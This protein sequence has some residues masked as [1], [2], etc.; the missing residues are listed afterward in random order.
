MIIVENLVN[1]EKLKW[2]YKH[3]LY[4][5]YPEITSINILLYVFLGFLQ[6]F[7]FKIKIVI[8]MQ[9]KYLT[10]LFSL[11]DCI[12]QNISHFQKFYGLPWW[13]KGYNCELPMQ[14][15][16]VRFLVR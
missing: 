7:S 6:S 8:K 11:Q 15:A 12:L 10:S 13:S 16:G 2:F 9:I 4:F 1:L 3:H 14:K 5:L